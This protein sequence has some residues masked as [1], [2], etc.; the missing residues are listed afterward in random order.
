[1]ITTVTLNPALDKLLSVDEIRVGETN[2]TRIISTSAAGKGIDVAKVLRDLDIEVTATGFLGGEIAPVFVDYMKKRK[3]QNC[4]VPIQECTRTNIQLFGKDGKRT[5]LLEKGPDVTAEECSALL[6]KTNELAQK[7]SVVT[8]CGSAP[9]GVSEDYF[10]ELMRT[11]RQ[12]TAKNPG[13]ILI[14]D[15]SGALLKAALKEKPYLI[16]PNRSE[17]MELMGNTDASDDEMI[18][19]AQ[20]LVKDGVSYILISMGKDG[21]MLVCEKGVWHGSAPDVDVKSTL[22]CGDTMVA[23]LSLSL[24]QKLEPDDMLRNAIALSSAN[25]MTFE[26]AHIIMAD[27][28]SLLKRC[29]VTKLEI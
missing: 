10:R 19:F 28:L 2:R 21:A 9:G 5:E 27:Y 29:S 25:A 15:T 14:T 3:I 20:Q 23:S 12:P 17:M 22:G 1:M 4:M 11:A 7:S 8:I 16:K 26:T 24:E 6:A 13:T 18:A